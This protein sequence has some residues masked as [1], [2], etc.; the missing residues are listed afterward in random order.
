MNMAEEKTYDRLDI[1][2]LIHAYLNGII[3]E[4]CF[5]NSYY[6]M[7]TRAAARQITDKTLFRYDFV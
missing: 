4:S 1:L 3:N 6:L 7:Y 5:E 2:N